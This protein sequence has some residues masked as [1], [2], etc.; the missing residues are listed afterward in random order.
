MPNTGPKLPFS[1]LVRLAVRQHDLAMRRPSDFAKP[2]PGGL[3]T[4]VIIH[5][6]TQ[7]HFRLVV[8][9]KHRLRSICRRL[10]AFVRPERRAEQDAAHAQRHDRPEHQ[11]GARQIVE[12]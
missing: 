1:H 3:Q 11:I 6:A 7:R 2:L 8:N 4:N 9:R 12:Q 10:A 5:G